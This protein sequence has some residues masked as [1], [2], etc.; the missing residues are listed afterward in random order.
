MI[1]LFRFWPLHLD[2]QNNL[3][4]DTANSLSFCSFTPLLHCCLHRN[5]SQLCCPTSP[6]DKSSAHSSTS[7]SPVAALPAKARTLPAPLNGRKHR[8]SGLIVALAAL[9]AWHLPTATHESPHPLP[10]GLAWPPGRHSVRFKAKQGKRHYTIALALLPCPSTSKLF[11]DSHSQQNKSDPKE[12]R[13]QH[14]ENAHD[15]FIHPRD[16]STKHGSLSAPASFAP[17]RLPDLSSTKAPFAVCDHLV[18]SPRIPG[19]QRHA[20]HH[21]RAAIMLPLTYRQHHAPKDSA[22]RPQANTSRSSSSHRPHRSRRPRSLPIEH[23]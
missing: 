21:E 1:A 8:D 7:P 22:R 3:D 4:T 6:A 20:G 13:K 11:D 2:S 5:I 19:Q 15:S 14:T 23:P 17:V 16:T 10:P 9:G 12:G 18:R